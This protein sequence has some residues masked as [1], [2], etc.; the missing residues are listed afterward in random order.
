[1]GRILKKGKQK[2]GLPAERLFE[3]LSSIGSI[4]HI[5]NG[6][7]DPKAVWKWLEPLIP[8]FCDNSSM[9]FDGSAADLLMTDMDPRKAI[10]TVMKAALKLLDEDHQ[11]RAAGPFWN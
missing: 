1:M 10:V 4:C 8:E 2:I 6:G 5:I 3:A 7:T 11:P 9:K